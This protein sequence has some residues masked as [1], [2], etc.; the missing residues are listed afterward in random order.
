[1]KIL[2]ANFCPCD[3]RESV[4]VTPESDIPVLNVLGTE[5]SLHGLNGPNCLG[6]ES[7]QEHNLLTISVLKIGLCKKIDL[8]TMCTFNMNRGRMCR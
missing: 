1:M 6:P 7:A 4:D 3:V 2:C 5:S 8:R